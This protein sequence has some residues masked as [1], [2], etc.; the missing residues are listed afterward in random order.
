[1]ANIPASD[2]ET[3]FDIMCQH[4]MSREQMQSEHG[5]LLAVSEPWV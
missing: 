5:R 4:A 2:V 3:H 1:M